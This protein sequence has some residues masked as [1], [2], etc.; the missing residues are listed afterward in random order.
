MAPKLSPKIAE[1]VN[2]LWKKNV[3]DLV[4]LFTFIMLQLNYSF[5]TNGCIPYQFL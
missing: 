5:F 1:L 2:E 3:S 4:T